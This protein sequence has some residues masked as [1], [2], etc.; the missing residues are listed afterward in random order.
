RRENPTTIGKD[1][2][3]LD[4]NGRGQLVG[5][6]L[7]AQGFEPGE[8]P[9]FEGNE[10]AYIDGK[11]ALQGDGSESSFNGCWYDVPG[12]WYGAYSMPFSGSLE[13]SKSIARTGG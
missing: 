3:Y 11:M 2:T 12:R 6:M 4:V 5:A 7:Q 1:Y 10:I 13:Y 8:T 9:F